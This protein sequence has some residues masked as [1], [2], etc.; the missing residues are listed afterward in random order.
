M[1]GQTYATYLNEAVLLRLTVGRECR[2]RTLVLEN[3]F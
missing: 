1:Q 3:G 2:A